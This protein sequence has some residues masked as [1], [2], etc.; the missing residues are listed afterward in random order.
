MS[1]TEKMSSPSRLHA[2]LI[3]TTR[4]IDKMATQMNIRL[5]FVSSSKY[6]RIFCMRNSL[7]LRM[8]MIQVKAIMIISRV[9]R[10]FLLRK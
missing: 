6:N 4:N 1:I 2:N 10:I 8:N 5:P 9:M 3:I 7:N